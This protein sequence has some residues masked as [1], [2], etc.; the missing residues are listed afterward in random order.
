MKPI[1]ANLLNAVLLCVLLKHLV[2]GAYSLIRQ[3]KK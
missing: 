1:L 2:G 3:P